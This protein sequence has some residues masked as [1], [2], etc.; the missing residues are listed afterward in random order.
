MLRRDPGLRQPASLEQLTQVPSVLA[1]ILRPPLGSPECSGVS[2]LGEVG[3]D[4][5]GLELLDHEAPAGGRLQGDGG[6][7]ALESAQ[8]VPKSDSGRRTNL[9][10]G[11]LSSFSVEAI[12]GDLVPVHVEAA[13]DGHGDLLE[14][15][16]DSCGYRPALSRGGPSTSHLLRTLSL[17]NETP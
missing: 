14:L 10:A 3:L 15:H 8:P 9:A 11:E 12:E 4:A 13:Y 1:I 7:S 17:S 2:R 6:L 16:V 5:S